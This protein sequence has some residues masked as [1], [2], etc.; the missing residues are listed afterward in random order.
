MNVDNVDAPAGRVVV[1]GGGIAGLAAAHRVL[2][3]GRS[4][5][6]LEAADRLGGK[7]HAG[8]IAGARVDLGAE[9]MLARRPEALDLASAVG[10]GGHL[11]PPATAAAAVWTRGA[12]RPLP[13]GHF[14]GVPGDAGGLGGLLSD[15]GLRAVRRDRELPPDAPGEDVAIGAYVARRMGREIVDRLVE[16]LLG[17]VYAGDAYRISMKAAAPKLLD[18]VRAHGTLTDAVRSLLPAPAGAPAPPRPRP[19]PVCAAASAD[20]RSPSPTPCGT[21]AA[22]SAPGPPCGG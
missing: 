22:R 14:M 9:S 12:L 11:Q 6:V 7:L 21:A 8:E 4:V 17:G 16:P 2:R 18:A 13:K 10:L 1:V 20:C 19:S 3:A 15:E 5:T